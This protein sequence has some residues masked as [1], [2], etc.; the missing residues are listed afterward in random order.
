MGLWYLKNPNVNPFVKPKRKLFSNVNNL[1]TIFLFHK[2]RFL[3]IGVSFK[4]G[5]PVLYILHYLFWYDMWKR[6]INVAKQLDSLRKSH[7]I[8]VEQAKIQ[9]LYF[10][11]PEL[12]WWFFKIQ[13]ECAAA[14]SSRMFNTLSSAPHNFTHTPNVLFQ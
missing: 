5:S 6:Q 9:R 1:T 2:S 14:N 3:Y 12:A 7:L 13:S 8:Q 4:W 10:L 11:Y